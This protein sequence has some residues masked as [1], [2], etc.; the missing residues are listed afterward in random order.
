MNKRHAAAVALLVVGFILCY[1]TVG[2]AEFHNVW[3]SLHTV[4]CV[5]GLLLLAAVIP[6]SGDVDCDNVDC[7]NI[8]EDDADCAD[9]GED[10]QTGGEEK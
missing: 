4:K 6:V 5:I 1:G 7:A 3:T 2:D 10:E 8:D 9:I